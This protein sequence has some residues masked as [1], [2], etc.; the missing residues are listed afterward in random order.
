[1]IPSKI[2]TINELN[3]PEILYEF[4]KIPHGLVLVTG[5]TGSGKSTTLAAM[6]SEI[7]MSSQKHIIT[8]E[9][10]I[11]YMYQKGQALVDQREIGRDTL[12][13]TGALRSTLRQDPDVV[14][15]GEMRD[16]QTI[17][18]TITIAETGHLVFAT[19]HTNS[20]AET[21]DRI[22]DVFPEHTQA[23]IRTQLASVIV[24][25][26]SQRLVPLKQGGRQAACEILI[27]TSAVRSSI[28]ESKTYQIDNI[29]Q[30]GADVG[31]FPLEKSL[32]EMVKKGDVT[33]DTA[34][35]FT[36]RPGLLKDLLQ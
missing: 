15:V 11:E 34:M 36:V 24:A 26:I 1:L 6:I 27:G 29:I 33:L 30:T 35:E 31:M 14:L 5:P 32:A 7:N 23:Q 9:D 19:L 20:A 2:K 3:L 22:I 25:V 13:W 10:P 28:R 4:M 8:L 21:V 12:S 17:A 16:Y 18:S